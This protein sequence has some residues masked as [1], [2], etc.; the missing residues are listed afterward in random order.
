[1][2][3]ATA[4]ARAFSTTTLATRDVRGDAAP[5]PVLAGPDVGVAPLAGL[6]VASQVAGLRM[7]DREVAHLADAHVV[8]FEVL[9]PGR[10]RDLRE[11]AGALDERAVGVGVEEVRR[12][13]LLEP[14]RVGL[15]HGADVFAV[16]LFQ[17]FVHGLPP[18]SRSS[19]KSFGCVS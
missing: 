17:V 6:A 10:P 11:E 16:E 12:E 14:A 5:A 4:D 18:I 2:V 13:V 15:L 8:A 9:H 3:F 7:D 1:M 19:L